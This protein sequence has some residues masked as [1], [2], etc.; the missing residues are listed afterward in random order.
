MAPIPPEAWASTQELI[1]EAKTS[2][3]PATRAQAVQAL[4]ERKPDR[5]WDVVR[6]ALQDPEDE[7]R[8][9]ALQGALGAGVVV[10]PDSLAR[11]A[12]SDP[13]SNVRFLALEGLAFDPSS[14]YL[15]PVLEQALNDPHPAVRQRANEILAEL[16]PAP[17]QA[18]PNPQQRVRGRR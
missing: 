10:P 6:D 3:N 14:P 11:L 15:L 9:R 7:V 8:T 16:N 17:R 12:L 1:K 5:A 13:S 2:V 18:A 4:L